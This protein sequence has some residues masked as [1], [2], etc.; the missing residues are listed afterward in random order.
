[1]VSKPTRS[2]NHHIMSPFQVLALL[3]GCPDPRHHH[4]PQP[5]RLAHAPEGVPYLVGQFSGGCQDQGV[6]A[7]RIDRQSLQYRKSKGEGLAFP[8]L[9]H[10]YT[11]PLAKHKSSL[12]RCGRGDTNT[13]ARELLLQPGIDR[14]EADGGELGSWSATGFGDFSSKV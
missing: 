12:D 14:G 1:M 5:H 11:V 9:G 2:G 10:P 6:D 13:K 7:I 8:C 4:I 3:D